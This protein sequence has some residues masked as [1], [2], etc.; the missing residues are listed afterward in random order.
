M[1]DVERVAK[2]LEMVVCPGCCG[3]LSLDSTTVEARCTEC[4]KSYPI[5]D[6]IPVLLVSRVHSGPGLSGESTER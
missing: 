6:G 5:V 3:R 1:Q 2:I 4:E